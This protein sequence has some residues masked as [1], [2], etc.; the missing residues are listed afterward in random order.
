MR[1]NK[2]QSSE[3]LCKHRHNFIISSFHQYF[4]VFPMK[5]KIRFRRLVSLEMNFLFWEDI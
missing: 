1:E 2:F 4:Q 3:N 5:F